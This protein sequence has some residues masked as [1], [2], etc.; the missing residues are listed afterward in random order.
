MNGPK[1]SVV[2][3]S[4]NCGQYIRRSVDSVRRQ[5]YSN[6]EIIIVDD[7]STDGTQDIVQ[8]IDDS[9]LRYIQQQNGGVAKARNTGI[10][11]ATGEFIAYVDADD[12]LDEHMVEICTACV[13]RTGADWCI[14]DILEV[15]VSD[16]DSANRL[17]RSPVPETGAR[18]EI[19]RE[20]FVLSA[21]F[22]RRK[23]LI[24]V[25]LYDTQLRTRE[26]WDMSV[27]LIWAGYH[28]SYIAEPL[29]RYHIRAD[30][31]MRNSKRLTYDCTL[32]VLNKHHRLRADEGDRESARIY[33][34]NIWWLGRE[35]LADEHDVL[36]CLYCVGQ[37]MKYDFNIRRL[38]NP[39]LS[40]LGIS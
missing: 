19:L 14:T 12:E 30:S 38:I 17:K 5:T 11:A 13:Q 24:D 21:P 27:R 33:A 22:F 34:T 29:Y 3:P 20:D 16:R 32:I 26:D 18:H 1:V 10:L 15:I 39:V 9:R 6:L 25:G 23:T 7:G 31:L 4:F 8:G 37:S 28:Y 2:I 35:Y 36:K 40:R